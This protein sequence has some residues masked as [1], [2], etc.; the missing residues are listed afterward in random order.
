MAAK[1]QLQ[2]QRTAEILRR[3]DQIGA[4]QDDN[5]QKGFLAACLDNEL[6]TTD[7]D[8]GRIRQIMLRFYFSARA[9]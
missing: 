6:P 3:S 4:P 1:S 7:G 2:F 8:V 9:G 5:R